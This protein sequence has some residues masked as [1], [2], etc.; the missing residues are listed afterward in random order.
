MTSWWNQVLANAPPSALAQLSQAGLGERLSTELAAARRRWPVATIRDEDLA[1]A[2]VAGIASQ[3][4]VAAALGRLRIEDLFL[5]QWCA[6]GDPRAIAAFETVHRAD[7]DAVLARFRRLAVAP[8][9]LQQLLRIKLFVGAAGKPPRIAEYSGFGFLQNWLRVT[10]LRALVDVARSERV[11]RLEELLADD[12]LVALPDLAPA[13]DARVGREQL[14]HA[15]KHAFARA[16]AGL[17]PRQRNFLRHAH[18]DA[19]TLD[20][21]AALY[22]VH[23]AT[24]ARTLAQARAD[25]VTETRRLLGEQ[26][27]VTPESLDSIVRAA[28]SRID[29]SLSRVLRDPAFAAGSDEEPA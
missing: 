3:R 18:V 9:E 23:R 14:R 11:R 1:R 4:D 10:A 19:L 17:A 2:L 27:G 20:Q 6:T 28:D 24:V 8:D 16:V 13:L 26:L 5:A 29:L 7:L 22:S 25:L 21:I 12:E 15:I